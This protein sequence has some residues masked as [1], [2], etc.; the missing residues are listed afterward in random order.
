M[1]W[2]I[3][4]KN[5]E[6][7]GVVNTPTWVSLEGVSVISKEGSIPDLNNYIWDTEAMDLLPSSNRLSRLEFMSRFTPEERIGI[8]SSS[9]PVVQDIMKLLEL[10]EFVSTSDPAT[11]QGVGYLV[12]SGIL[13]NA[14]AAEV[15]Q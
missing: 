7:V 3:L 4:H 13:T 10:A 6:L 8:R 9:N 12:Y 2:Y 5:G 11:Q 14:R 1:S 15:L